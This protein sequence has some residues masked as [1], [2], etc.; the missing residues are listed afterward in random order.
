MDSIQSS[1]VLLSTRRT[2]WLITAAFVKIS[3]LLASK[4]D[5]ASLASL[6]EEANKVP[7]FP[8]KIHQWQD[9]AE[10]IEI[11]LSDITSL[12]QNCPD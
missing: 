5:I 10:F 1:N 11:A 12:S 3:N 8:R 6:L 2:K 7:T 9:A 4:T